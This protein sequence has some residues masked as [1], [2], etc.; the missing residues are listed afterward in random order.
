M[1]ISLIRAQ[2]AFAA[3]VAAMSLVAILA[4]AA[5]LADDCPNAQYRTGASA[6]L[7]DCRAYEMVSPP[8][9]NGGDV[10]ADSTRTRARADGNMVGYSSLV[11]F[12]DTK[13]MGVGG[14]YLARRTATPATNGWATDPITPAQPALTYVAAISGTSRSSMS[15]RWTS[16]GGCIGRLG[17]WTVSMPA[18]KQDRQPLP[19][20]GPL[21]TGSGRDTLLTEASSPLD[22]SLNEVAY[23]GSTP[24]LGH[25]IF[26]SAAALTADA[27]LS[28]RKLYETTPAGVTRLVSR[29]PASGTSCDDDNGPACVAS[30][31]RTG[32]ANGL[33]FRMISDN[34]SRIFFQAPVSPNPTIGGS[35]YMRENATT[36][37]QLNA[38][39]KTT[40]E[41]PLPARL[42]TA[43]T[44][45]SRVFFTTSEGLVD[46]DDNNGPDLYMY[47]TE[48]G[49]GSHLTRISHRADPTA[50][51]GVAT[52]I[53]ASRDGRYVYFT[54]SNEQL[55]DGEPSFQRV[56][57]FMWH[58]GELAYIGE[59]GDLLDTKGNGLDT[60]Y[61]YWINMLNSRVSP[62]GRHL[63]FYAGIAPGLLVVVGL[64][65]MTTGTRAGST[66]VKGVSVVS[67]LCI[68]RI[69][70][71]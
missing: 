40:P 21:D 11:G 36:T 17:R 42:W 44:D 28:G 20:R 33:K 24:D 49:P 61:G 7:P 43:S 5:A 58:D 46:G 41:A 27:P 67:C 19:P 71:R 52:V 56:G 35:V 37:V 69:R 13:G 10:M 66:R 1:T 16:P 4:P 70:V 64:G 29:I 6:H 51:T 65:A 8:N 22:P 2:A 50:P 26:E 25:A 47:D 48:G 55:V 3:T 32:P 45:G 30:N 23:S 39:E 34:G 15:S 59:P 63:L 60:L 53:G 38:S 57:V 31:G 9:K 54:N 62:D 68:A 14:E 18:I 12:G